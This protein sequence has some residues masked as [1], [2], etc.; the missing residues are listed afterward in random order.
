MT[1]PA[2]ASS[3]LPDGH[4]I[5]RKESMPWLPKISFKFQST[6]YKEPKLMVSASFFEN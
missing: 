2:I 3:N 1:V 4:K 6:K 5:A